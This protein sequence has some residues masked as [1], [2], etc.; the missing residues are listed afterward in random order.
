MN[1][2]EEK[3]AKALDLIDQ[4]IVLEKQVD[5][6]YK[7][8][9]HEEKGEMMGAGDNIVVFHLKVLKDLVKEL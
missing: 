3:K 5:L 6:V 9:L 1:E 7:K 2:Q 8:L 4:L